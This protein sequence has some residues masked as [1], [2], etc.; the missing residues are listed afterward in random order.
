MVHQQPPPQGYPQYYRPPSA[1]P[2]HAYPLHRTY[3]SIQDAADEE[4]DE[5]PF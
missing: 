3:A 1:N 4:S 2:S 5:D